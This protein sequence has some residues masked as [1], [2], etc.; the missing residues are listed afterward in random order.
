MTDIEPAERIICALDTD[1]IDEATGLAERLK[2]RVGAVKLGLEFFTAHGSSGVSRVAESGMP[3]FLDLKFSDIPNTVAGAMRGAARCAPAMLTIHVTGG[4]AMMRAAAAAGL[5][6]A[7]AAGGVRPKILGV[8]VLTSF[9]EDDVAAVGMQGPLHDQ[10]LRL[11]KLAA[12]CGLDGVV[13]SAHEVSSLRAHC[14]PDFTLV[15]PGIRPGWASS[16][17]QKRIVTPSE[18]V[19]LGAD[20][21]VI[22]RPITRSDDPAGAAERIG[23]EMAGVSA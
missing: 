6:I 7:D 10:V 5:R 14:G 12:Q 11:A 18:A 3:I 21:L 1:D 19:R 13:A 17:D 4:P 8:T 16:D 2:G 22:G 9:D 15:V 23:Q 20:Y